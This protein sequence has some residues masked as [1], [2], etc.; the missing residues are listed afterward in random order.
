MGC[1]SQ[2]FIRVNAAGEVVN[3]Q[4]DV[5]SVL[6]Q[7]DRFPELAKRFRSVQ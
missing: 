7:Y 1:V 4:G 3:R 2:E 5:Y 6:H